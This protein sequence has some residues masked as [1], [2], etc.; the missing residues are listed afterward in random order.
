MDNKNNE[1]EFD[2]NYQNKEGQSFLHFMAYEGN[3]VAIRVFLT[4]GADPN[5]ADKNGMTPL[6]FAALRGHT[7]AIHILLN[8]GADPLKKTNDGQ[9]IADMAR[10][11]DDAN[12]ASQIDHIAH[13]KKIHISYPNPKPKF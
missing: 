8:G 13:R 3:D 4:A 10:H 5:L 9:T 12:L 11:F 7:T 2:P 6:H 1:D